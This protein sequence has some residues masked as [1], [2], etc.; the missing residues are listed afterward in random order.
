[1][2]NGIP[3]MTISAN[4]IPIRTLIGERES[5]KFLYINLGCSFS[6]AIGGFFLL[7]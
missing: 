2:D 1:M 6:P 5:C 4:I 7:D 3:N